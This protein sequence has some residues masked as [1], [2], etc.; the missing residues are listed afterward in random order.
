MKTFGERVNSFLKSLGSEKG[1]DK[2]K[3][4][5]TEDP[6]LDQGGEGGEGG[7]DGDDGEVQKSDLRDATEILVGLVSELKE[8]NK[9][10]SALAKRQDGIEKSQADIGE[11]VVGVAEL[12][13]KI[14]NS[15]MPRKTA[16]AK[17]LGGEDDGKG[18]GG[19][20]GSG[21]LDQAEFEKAQ[22]VLTKACTEGRIAV[23]EASK[24][25]SDM[26]KAMTIPGYQMNP[27]YRSF[28]AKELKA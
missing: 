19:V 1:E 27:E 26:Q 11:A 24:I 2:E 17:S 10:L 22:R 8:V 21:V 20:A 5:E 3:E 28:I 15:P 25:E 18:G 16:M 4:E 23:F 14:A 13:S 12:V 9:S 7:E 6:D